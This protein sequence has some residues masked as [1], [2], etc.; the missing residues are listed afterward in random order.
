MQREKYEIIVVGGGH[1]G[2]EAALAC[3]RKGHDTL[4]LCLGLGTVSMMACNPAI[5]G[6]AKG[7]LVRE[8]D[9]LGG[10]MALAADK[11]LVQIKM[12]NSA[13]GPAVFSLRGQE[14]KAV[15]QRVIADALRRTPRLTVRVGEGVEVL[16][17]GGAACGVKLADGEEIFSDS[18]ILATGVYLNGKVIIGEYS[19]SSG[20]SGQDRK[21][22]V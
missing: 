9:A 17:S 7:H 19:K 1:A 14:D 5:G 13:K 15:Y 21:S 3:A 18:V 4:M 8:I 22:V 12:L 10:E 6:T 2:V 20:P 11:A 16:L